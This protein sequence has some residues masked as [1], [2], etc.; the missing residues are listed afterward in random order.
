MLKVRLHRSGIEEI[1]E[2]WQPFERAV[3]CSFFQSWAWVGC[4]GAERFTSPVLVEATRDG[5]TVAMALFNRHRGRLWLAETGKPEWDA[6][7]VE[8]NGPLLAPREAEAWRLCLRRAMRLG[9]GLVLS[10]IGARQSETAA[11][12]GLA[13]VRRQVRVAPYVNLRRGG[14]G[15]ADALSPNTRYQLNR[16]MRAYARLGPLRITPAADAAQAHEYLDAMGVL[17]Q[18]RW[19][20]RGKPGAFANPAFARFHHALIDRSRAV[21]LLRINA[22]DHV[23]GYLHNFNYRGRVSAYQSGFNYEDAPQH[24]KPGMTCH[25]LAIERAVGNG[26]T[27]YDFLGGAD[28]YKTSLATGSEPLEWLELAGKWS[29][30]G[31]ASRA[32][33]AVLRDDQPVAA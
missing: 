12:A 19:T 17:H 14:L 26:M 11:M 9:R 31:L 33:R 28:R 20:A 32:R 24:A 29:L 7:F 30:R 22:G 8:H 10:G 16:S 18:A 15:H 13:V 5:I 2:L 4:L 27:V 3:D 21:E 23:V 6:V 1:G 25:H